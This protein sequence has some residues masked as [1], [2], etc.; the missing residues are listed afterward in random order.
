MATYL[1]QEQAKA[2]L[3]NIGQDL[4]WNLHDGEEPAVDAAFDTDQID[5]DIALCEAEVNSFLR[6][7]YVMPISDTD[8]KVLLRKYTRELLLEQAYLRQEG[9]EVPEDVTKRVEGVRSVLEKIANGKRRLGAAIIE[10]DDDLDLEL[11]SNTPEF[12]RDKM[13]GF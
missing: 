5:E 13:G 10:E 2:F 9:A 8:T 1:S 6:G 3:S 12:T 11:I 4:Y 7:R